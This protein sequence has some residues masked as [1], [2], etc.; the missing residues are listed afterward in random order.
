MIL[1]LLEPQIKAPNH[2]P[3]AIPLSFVN[4][5]SIQSLKTPPRREKVILTPKAKEISIP[6]NEAGS[7]VDDATNKVSPSKPKTTRSTRQMI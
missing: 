6:L 2:N 7:I 5:G 4:I 3:N 1:R